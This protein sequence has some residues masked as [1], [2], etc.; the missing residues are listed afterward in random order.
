[1][2]Y[3]SWCWRCGHTAGDVLRWATQAVAGV[4]IPTQAEHPREAGGSS[5]GA[6]VYCLRC[7]TRHHAEHPLVSV[8]KRNATGSPETQA[9]EPKV[10]SLHGWAVPLRLPH[11]KA[12]LLWE[13]AVGP[14]STEARVKAASGEAVGG[15]A[16]RVTGSRG[17][18]FRLR[19]E[20]AGGIGGAAPGG[21]PT[22]SS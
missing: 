21:Q 4:V 17:T 16:K 2:P 13:M 19:N 7:F 14:M 10:V 6:A 8:A 22:V 11:A 5:P 12:P 3:L 20:E 18:G 15:W 1:M 9:V